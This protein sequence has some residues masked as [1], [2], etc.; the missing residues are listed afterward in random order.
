[1]GVG[2]AR[3]AGEAA[4]ASR[5]RAILVCR[6][7]RDVGRRFHRNA[8]IATDM[9]GRAIRGHAD[10]ERCMT[11]GPHGEGGKAARVGARVA[12]VAGRR[13]GGDVGGDLLHGAA[14]AGAMASVALAGRGAG[15]GVACAR[16][17]REAA[18]AARSRAVLVRR[19]GRDVVEGFT[20]TPVKLP[21]WQ[22]VQ[23][24]VVLTL[25]AVCPADPIEKVAKP[26]TAVLLWQASQVA[27]PVGTWPAF[28]CMAPPTPAPW[29]LI[30]VPAELVE[31]TK[32]ARRSY[33]A[34]VAVH[35]IRAADSDVGCRLGNRMTLERCLSVMAGRAI[36]GNARVV[37][38]RVGE[39][40]G[41]PVTCVAG[42]DLHR[43][44]I[45]GLA[46]RTRGPGAVISSGRTAGAFPPPGH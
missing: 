3:E 10:A 26:P 20:T 46:H 37:H 32:A 43:N 7:G 44:V 42:R 15:M 13:A 23:S 41:V 38:R 12:G 34:A 22:L 40:Y 17:G 6:A 11:G 1:M 33:I 8:Q 4:V 14:R 5:S 39:G 35:A 45:G 18:M 16:E 9:A 36:R 29:Q 28:T 19:G 30:T 27:E 21:I 31:W 24:E 25:S 2:G